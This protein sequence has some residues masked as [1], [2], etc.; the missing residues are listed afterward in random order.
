MEMS[1]NQNHGQQPN[2]CGWGAV[3][4]AGSRDGMILLW[5]NIS[6][7]CWHQSCAAGVSSHSLQPVGLCCGHNYPPPLFCFVLLVCLFVCFL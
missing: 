6:G 7:A 1:L 2:S 5:S 4:G 3:L